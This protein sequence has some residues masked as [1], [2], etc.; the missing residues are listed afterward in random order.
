MQGR[1]VE[2]VMDAR[3]RRCEQTVGFS[4]SLSGTMCAMKEMIRKAP[5]SCEDEEVKVLSEHDKGELSETESEG[6]CMCWKRCFSCLSWVKDGHN[7]L[8]DA[9]ESRERLV[10][11]T[12]FLNERTKFD[13]LE[14]SVKIFSMQRGTGDSTEV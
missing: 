6:S 5:V 14:Q 1:D 4:H 9:F 11:E 12:R 2:D 3:R 13:R 10:Q 7:P 8:V